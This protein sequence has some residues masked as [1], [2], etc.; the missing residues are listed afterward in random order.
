M[1]TARRCRYGS[2]TFAPVG[3]LR[4]I[5]THEPTVA[6]TFGLCAL[7]K[8]AVADD[9]VTS[10]RVATVEWHPLSLEQWA[11]DGAAA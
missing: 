2:C 3:T 10:P 4:V 8:T 9:A 6:R 7:H 5:G 1:T 11:Q